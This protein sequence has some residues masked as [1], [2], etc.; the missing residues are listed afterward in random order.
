MKK[1]EW[2]DHWCERHAH[3]KPKR[4]PRTPCDLLFIFLAVLG[5]LA[6]AGTVMA[7]R[8]LLFKRRVE[9]ALKWGASQYSRERGYIDAEYKER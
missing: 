7:I 1:F 2:F 9:T 5:V 3:L 4:L 8:L 6:V